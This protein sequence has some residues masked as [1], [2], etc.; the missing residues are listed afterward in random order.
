MIFSTAQNEKLP[1]ITISNLTAEHFGL[2][3]EAYPKKFGNGYGYT[4]N[5]KISLTHDKTLRIKIDYLTLPDKTINIFSILRRWQ[6]LAQEHGATKIELRFPSIYENTD[7]TISTFSKRL[8]KPKNDHGAIV[9]EIPVP[10]RTNRCFQFHS[11]IF[12]K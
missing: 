11:D 6:H 4:Y 9:F 5:G 2:D 12:V 8:G 7:K 3:P 1:P 10:C